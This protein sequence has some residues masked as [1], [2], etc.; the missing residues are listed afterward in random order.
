MRI[1]SFICSILVLRQVRS[2]F[3]RGFCTDCDLVL[4]L[5]VYSTIYFP[6][7]HPAA[8]YGF[9]FSFFRHF[10]EYISL[11]NVFLKAV[12]TQDVTNSVSL[13]CPLIVCMMYPSS[14]TL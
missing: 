11:N 7:G 12:H 5:S 1:H 8:A 14:L 2:L 4:T 3:Q 13:P 9:F 10:Y 6:S